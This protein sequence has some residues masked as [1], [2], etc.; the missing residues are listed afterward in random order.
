MHMKLS[1]PMLLSLISMTA[2][3]AQAPGG[4]VAGLVKDADGKPLPSARVLLVHSETDRRRSVLADSAGGFTISN[5]PPGEYR[6]E[7]EHE[8]HQKQLRRFTLPLN[9]E[10]WIDLALLPGRRTDAVEVSASREPLRAQS[11]A[12]GGLVDNRAITGLPLDGRNFFQLGLLLPGVAPPAEG[13]AG[14]VRGSFAVNINGARE[15]S[16]NFLLDGVYNGDPKL[17]GPAVTPPV[18]AVR[19]FEVAAG[20]YDAT[21]GRNSGGQFN[22]ALKSGGNQFHGTAYEFFRNG[23][24]DA[25]NFFAPA[26]EAR[27]QYQRNQFGASAGGPVARN[28]TFFFADYEGRRLREGITQVTTV[29]TALERVGDFSK[30]SVYAIDPMTQRPFPNNIIPSYY[31]N[32]IGL[33]IAALYPLPVRSTPSGNFVSSPAARDREDHFDIRMDHNLAA[34]DDLAV[35]YSFGDRALYESFTGPSYSK[36][37]GYGD[38]VP[39]RSQNAMASETHAFSPTLLNDF[40]LGFTRIS[41]GVYQQNLGTNVNRSV[42]LPTVSTNARDTGLSLINLTGYSP[43]GD[44][45]NNPQH[46]ATTIYQV[47]DTVTAARGRHLLRA[48]ID[49]RWLRQNAYR[50]VLAMGYLNFLGLITGNALEELLLGMPTVTGVANVDNAQHLRS[51]SAYGFVEDTWRVRP[52]LTVS[53]G[54]RYEYNAPPVDAF[55]RA[56]VFDA[57]TQS[58]VHAGTNGMPRSGYQADRNNWAPRIGVAW[59]PG[60]AGTTLRAGYGLH[61]DQGSLATGEGLYFN[62]PYYVSRLYY[63]SQQY[64]LSLANPFPANYPVAAAPSALA[65]QRTLRSA[66]AQQ[67]NFSV[68][69]E[70]GRSRTLE[71]AYAGS[72]GTKLLGARDLN[73]PSPNTLP[74]NPRPNPAFSDVNLV[75]SRGNSIYHSMQTR[76][77][78]T[79]HRGLSALASYT[80]SK[81][82]DDASGFFSSAGD[83]NYPQDSRNAAAERGLSNFDLRHRFSLSYVYDLPLGKGR[84]RGGWRTTGIWSLQSGV[85]FSAYLLSGM[86]NS[87]TGISTLGFGSN[88][89]PNLLQSPALAHP[90]PDGWFNTAAFALPRFGSFGS[91][92]R[93]ILTGP[94]LQTANLALLKD[95]ALSEGKALQFRAEVFNSLNHANFSLPD[96]FLGS[97]TFGKIQSAGAPRRIQ[98]GVKFVF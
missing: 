36:V 24:T 30:S 76:F 89:R 6:L 5:L 26:R 20:V 87:N 55:D 64:P 3:Q 47:L 54:L 86:D 48:G 14:S 69:R 27:P 34:G 98:L 92:G 25:R 77:Q 82:I 45:Y 43:L 33:A 84:L 90:G 52:G 37:P 65:F 38:N 62:A 12:L 19:E 22:V 81:S 57:A 68:Q 15:D 72:K 71:L 74:Y 83:A 96:N 44:E 8:G 7:A 40:R 73:Q 88:D 59:S 97:P 50:D 11:S 93:N 46:S 9:H 13:S 61:Y 16:N 58:L 63:T 60:N 66:Y 41:T 39:A 53:A 23:V 21:L 2:V 17:N 78:Q 91:A 51:Q 10:L 1:F 70:V 4:V 67:W 49:L 80:W 31:M 35:R 28:R 29:P 95:T 94:G 18:D 56:N 42:G 79:L 32:P 85:P 75:E